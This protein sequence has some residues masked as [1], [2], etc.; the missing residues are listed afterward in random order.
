VLDNTDCDD[1]FNTVYPAATEI[2]DNLDNDC[3]GLVD[4][5]LPLFTYYW[6]GDGDGH[7]ANFPITVACSVPV[8]YAYANDDCND[9]VNTINPGALEICN[10][11]DDNCNGL[12]DSDDP[13]V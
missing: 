12:I 7:G 5:N 2:C 4:E 11:I 10:S 13:G 1:S 6:D 3:D 8:G 9:A